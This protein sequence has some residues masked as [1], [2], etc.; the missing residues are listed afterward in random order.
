MSPLVFAHIAEKDVQQ[1][2]LDRKHYA[3]DV[4]QLR[5][6]SVFRS[7]THTESD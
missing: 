2:Q 7:N 5:R 4:D 3:A 1:C 6:S